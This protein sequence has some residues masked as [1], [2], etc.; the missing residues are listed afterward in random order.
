MRET[1]GNRLGGDKRPYYSLWPSSFGDYG[2]ARGLTSD[3][4]RI[5]WSLRGGRSLGLAR[6]D[7]RPRELRKEVQ[8]ERLLKEIRLRKGRTQ[9]YWAVFPHRKTPRKRARYRRSPRHDLVCTEEGNTVRRVI[10]ESFPP[11]IRRPISIGYRTSLT[12]SR[13]PD[14]TPPCS[15]RSRQLSSA[16]RPYT[17]IGN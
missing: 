4:V 11:S 10:D 15:L 12:R 7:G 14:R 6:L 8:E 17:G 16:F 9:S 1:L 13:K 5:Y 2:R 3:R